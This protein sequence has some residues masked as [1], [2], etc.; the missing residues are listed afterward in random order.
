L[1]VE[2]NVTLIGDGFLQGTDCEARISAGTPDCVFEFGGLSTQPTNIVVILFKPLF[3]LSSICF[4]VV[5][6]L[7][8]ATHNADHDRQQY[9]RNNHV[10]VLCHVELDIIEDIDKNKNYSKRF[11][12]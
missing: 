9:D 8:G 12:I 1:N 4:R 6:G 3:K 11:S 5:E 10:R 7:L 2:E